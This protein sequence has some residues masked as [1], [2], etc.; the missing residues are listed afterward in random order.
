[1]AFALYTQGTNDNIDP[2]AIANTTDTAAHININID[3]N[4]LD[5]HSNDNDIDNSS[6]ALLMADID[7]S[8]LKTTNNIDNNNDVFFDEIYADSDAD[9]TTT[10]ELIWILLTLSLC[11]ISLHIVILLH[12]R[13]TGPSDEVIRRKFEE[14]QSWRSTDSNHD[15]MGNNISNGS[16]GIHRKRKMLAYW[17]YDRYRRENNV[18]AFLRDRVKNWM[19]V[20]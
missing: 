3:S 6:S 1:M 19:Y 20:T 2:N 14:G 18:E 11:S 17:V 13:S 9:V 12:V 16:N 4:D 10:Y 15:S 5:L 7:D 8:S